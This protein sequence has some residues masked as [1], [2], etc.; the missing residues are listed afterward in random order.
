MFVR[1]RE[2]G[3]RLHL[4]L[5][6]TR[7]INGKVRQEHFASLG[8]IET[9]QTVPGRLTFWQGLHERQPVGLGIIEI[10][11]PLNRLNNLASRK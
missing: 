3:R 2:S 4:R 11:K 10:F 9:P 8:S 6:E 5:V 7:R 1:F